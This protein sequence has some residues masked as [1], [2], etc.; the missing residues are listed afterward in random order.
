[1][2]ITLTIETDNVLRHKE[3]ATAV[4]KVI[5]KNLLLSCDKVILSAADNKDLLKNI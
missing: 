4:G 2:D 3:N 1:M 5:V